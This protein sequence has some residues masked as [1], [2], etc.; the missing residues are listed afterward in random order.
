MAATITQGQQIGALANQIAGLQ[1]VMT[2]IQ[3]VITNS[4]TINSMTAQ[5]AAWGELTAAAP[6]S[7]QSTANI[8]NAVLAELNPMLA[9][10][11]AQFATL[12]TSA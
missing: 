6:L 7:V 2:S 9:A 11:N 1:A 12:T 3:T 8:L 4:D 5:C 10:L